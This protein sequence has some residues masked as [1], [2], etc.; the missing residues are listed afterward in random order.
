MHK[1]GIDIFFFWPANEIKEIYVLHSPLSTL[2]L[3]IHNSNNSKK[4]FYF[5]SKTTLPWTMYVAFF[6]LLTIWNYIFVDKIQSY[7]FYLDG[8]FRNLSPLQRTVSHEKKRPRQAPPPPKKKKKKMMITSP[9][10][11]DGS[12]G[13]CSMCS[14]R[15]FGFLG[16][17]NFFFFFC[18]FGAFSF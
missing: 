10:N 2:N 13:L 17:L 6:F 16:T 18:S 5:F 3:N 1:V 11:Y 15:S 9:S 14:S 7:Q 4:I 8:L 12:D